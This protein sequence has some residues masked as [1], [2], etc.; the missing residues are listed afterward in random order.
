MEGVVVQN[1][2]QVLPGSWA[3]NQFARYENN[4]GN[5]MEQMRGS[6]MIVAT[7][8]ASLTFQIAINPPG[9]VWQENSSIQQGCA[10]GQTCKAGTSV[11]AFGDSDQKTRYELF[12][13]LCTISFSASQAIIVLLICGFPLRNKFVMWFLILIT[14]LSVFC[15]AGAY[16]I[17]IWMILNPLDGIF[18]KVNL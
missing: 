16:V 9:G 10:P 18:Y 12:L 13:L 14:C 11:L 1:G 6:L 5:W 4:Q 7:V 3:H 17:A 8:I 2:A 15:T